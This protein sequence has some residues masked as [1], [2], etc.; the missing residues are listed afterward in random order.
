MMS[1]F[2]ILKVLKSKYISIFGFNI[3]HNT[4]QTFATYSFQG[5]SKG[6]HL[7]VNIYLVERPISQRCLSLCAWASL[8]HQKGKTRLLRSNYE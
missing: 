5:I 3:L 4:P 2:A 7:F 6:A 1:I 8:H